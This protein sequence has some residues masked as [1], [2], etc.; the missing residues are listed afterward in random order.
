WMSALLAAALRGAG[1]VRAPAVISLVGALVLVPLSPLLLF[2]WGPIPRF[3]IAG[4]GAAVAIYSTVSALALVIYLCVGPMGLRLTPARLRWSLFKDILSVGGLSALGTIQTNLTVALVTG[5]VGIYGTHAIAGYGIASRLDY[6]LVP[7]LFGFGTGVIT[8]VGT[9]V[10][11]GDK[12]RARRVAWVGVLIGGGTTALIGAAVAMFPQVWVGLFSSDPVVV[13]TGTQYLRIVAP[14]YGFFGIGMMIYFASQGADRVAIP[15]FGGLGRLVL[16]GFGGW[17][18][19]AK[20][21]I[22]LSSLFAIVA[23]SY[24]L[25]ALVCIAGMKVSGW[26]VARRRI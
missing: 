2:G 9:A 25:Y 26:G 11:A 10:G 22:G 4:G 20:F 14:F 23:A 6:L 21:G 3:G 16:A 8:M 7:I 15:F 5:A 24:A 12:A 1:L 19:A 17:I 18:V 13:A